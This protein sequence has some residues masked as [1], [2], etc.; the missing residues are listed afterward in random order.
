MKSFLF[1]VLGLVITFY[2][3][4]YISGLVFINKTKKQAKEYGWTIE[5]MNRLDQMTQDMLEQ[6]EKMRRQEYRENMIKEAQAE[7]VDYIDYD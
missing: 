5:D 4:F 2:L 1:V 6:E 3:F 7:E